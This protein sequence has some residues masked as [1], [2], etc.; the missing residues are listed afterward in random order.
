MRKAVLLGASGLI[1]GFLLRR[2]LTEDSFDAV[3]IFSRK[4]IQIKHPKIQ[5]II[6][7]FSQLQKSFP[8]IVCTDVFCC[9]GTT[10]AVAGSQAAFTQ[11]DYDYPLLVA[12]QAKTYGATGFWV[13]TTTN[14]NPESPFFYSR[15]KGQL[16]QSLFSCHFE[17]LG[18][19]RPSLLLGKRPKVRYG[20]M[21]MQWLLPK[22]HRIMLGKLR[23]Y[24]AVS[25]EKVADC[26]FRLSLNAPKGCTIIES[27]AIL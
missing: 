4:P 20:E 19:V 21:L 5:E 13:I 16:E 15:I 11:I 14:A 27:E 24:R 1:G 10:M 3:I 2:L 23:R 25:A 26:L 8:K 17:S 6:T 7:D 18:V 9:L 22:L 12:N